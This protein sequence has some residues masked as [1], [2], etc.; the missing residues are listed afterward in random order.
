MMVFN[1]KIS[2]FHKKSFE[3]LK[4][5]FNYENSYFVITF[6]TQALQRKWKIPKNLDQ[7]CYAPSHILKKNS[8]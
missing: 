3:Y 2:Y 8:Y 7:N 1:W 4:D 5:L 6:T